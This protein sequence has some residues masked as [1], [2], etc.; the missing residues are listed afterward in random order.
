[1]TFT[2]RH[3]SDRW[4]VSVAP[5]MGAVR[6]NAEQNRVELDTPAGIAIADYRMTPGVMTLF[7]TEV[8]VTLRGRG[9]GARL[10]QGALEDAR[11]A[12]VKVV[13]TCW[14]V[15]EFIDRNPQFADLLR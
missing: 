5:D 15:R 4:V 10:V 13:P 8:P 2:P 9:I 6:H 14:F 1:M 12:G 3:A 11:R 7:H